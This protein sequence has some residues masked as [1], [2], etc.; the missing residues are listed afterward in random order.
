MN[1]DLYSSSF[2]KFEYIEINVNTFIRIEAII[3]YFMNVVRV[4][5]KMSSQDDSISIIIK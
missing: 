2:W 5:K 4:I 1:I 3:L